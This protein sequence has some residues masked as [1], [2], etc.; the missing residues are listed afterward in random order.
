MTAKLRIELENA[1][2]KGFDEIV[3]DLGKMGVEG[4][5]TEK[6]IEALNKELASRNAAK[7]TEQVKQLADELDGTTAALRK[8]KNEQQQLDDALKASHNSTIANSKAL[9]DLNAVAQR[10]AQSTGKAADYHRDLQQAMDERKTRAYKEQISK[11]ADEMTGLG[12]ASKGAAKTSGLFWTEANSKFQMAKAAFAMF[13]G[14]FDAASAFSQK[15]AE[16]GNTSFAKL[17]AAGSKVKDAMISIANDPGLSLQVEK[18]AA[19]IEGLGPALAQFGLNTV[20]AFGM[21]QDGVTAL[22]GAWIKLNDMLDASPWAASIL[23]G[24]APTLGLLRAISAAAGITGGN[25]AKSKEWDEEAKAR[26]EADA[27]AMEALKKKRAEEEAARQKRK[28]EAEATLLNPGVKMREEQAKQERLDAIKGLAGEVQIQNELNVLLATQAALVA[29]IKA[30]SGD[31]TVDKQVLQNAKDLVDLETKR[32][33]LIKER[34]DKQKAK[35]K[36]LA[37]AKHASEKKAYD[38]EIKFI[39]TLLKE[40]TQSA[41]EVRDLEKRRFELV[42]AN[43]DLERKLLLEQGVLEQHLYQEEMD[44][45]EARKK[46][47][48]DALL[49]VIDGEK[50]LAA[51]RR[52]DREV[53]LAAA[54]DKVDKF[55]EFLTSMGGGGSDNNSTQITYAPTFQGGGQGGGGGGHECCCP[56]PGGGGGGPVGG[57]SNIGGQGPMG[58]QGVQGG[59]GGGY[60]GWY[61]GGGGPGGGYRGPTMPMPQGWHGQT[62]WPGGGPKPRPNPI[63]LLTGGITPAGVYGKLV[64][65]A[66]DESE[67]KRIQA[68]QAEGKLDQNGRPVDFKEDEKKQTGAK[69]RQ[70]VKDRAKAAGI[71]VPGGDVQQAF[72]DD[73]RTRENWNKQREEFTREEQSSDQYKEANRNDRDRKGGEF[74]LTPGRGIGVM[75]DSKG[76]PMKVDSKEGQALTHKRQ[77]EQKAKEKADAEQLRTSDATPYQKIQELH[78]KVEALETKLKVATDMQKAGADNKSDNLPALDKAKEDAGKELATAQGEKAKE[79]EK[80]RKFEKDRG[81]ESSARTKAAQDQKQKEA[82]E[83]AERLKDDQ[84]QEASDNNTIRDAAEQ[85]LPASAVPEDVWERSD[86][87]FDDAV[88]EQEDAQKKVAARKKKERQF[89]PDYGPETPKQRADARKKA[90]MKAKTSARQGKAKVKSKKRVELNRGEIKGTESTR[91]YHDLVREQMGQLKRQGNLDQTQVNAIEQLLEATREGAMNTAE[92]QEKM[93]QLIEEIAN[94]RGLR[95]PKGRRQAVR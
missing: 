55:K 49:A 45:I 63:G 64:E 27:K 17:N 36:E 39:D 87:R 89:T 18:L 14:A 43:K 62:P 73:R 5:D 8:A 32:A 58:G 91:A 80:V 79:L 77:A 60:G 16:D 70:W 72:G 76:Q 88:R 40:N 42:K 6:A 9:Q 29:K 12:Q 86:E 74:V 28:A 90:D 13:K 81:Q 3:K 53:E 82:A 47:E 65:T 83:E 31:P 24:A 33:Q 25:G 84:E 92:L 50:D 69:G 4:K 38:E 21:A 48:R 71:D 51:R 23:D 94:M 44:R 54:Q 41:T 22:M 34:L 67:R 78:K 7:M 61:P 93:D 1:T 85:G 35:E 26:A 66:Q 75:Y 20:S 15:M 95:P 56:C 46:K 10:T 57:N 19:S 2:K 37:D 68:G 11:L 30:S 59:Y 52:H